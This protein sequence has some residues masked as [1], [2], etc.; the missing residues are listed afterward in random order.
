MKTLV[1]GATGTV[2]SQVTRGLVARGQAVRVLTRSADKAKSL[3]AGVEARVGDLTSP[4]EL[5]PVFDGVDKLFLLNAVSPTETQEGL[6]ALDWAKTVGV[7]TLVYLS[8]QHV[9]RGPHIPHFGGKFAIEAAI[10]ESGLDYTI[11][12]PN[13]FYQNDYWLKDA[14]L[15]YGVYAQPI[16]NVG[17]SRVDVRDIAAAAV[18]VLTTDAHRNQTYVLAGPDALTGADCAAAYSR[19]LGKP[20]AYMG[21]DLD[22]WEQQAITMLPGWMAFDFKIMYRFFQEHGLRATAADLDKMQKVV[23]HAPRAFDA[24]VA[25]AVGSWR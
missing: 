10:R 8:V 17:L 4:R 18:N 13:N 3:P 21:D 24:F 12:Q 1:L 20:V 14:I 7:R 15:S 22:A 6:S 11:L 23:G 25:E 2:G 5:G 16:G 9:E 19:H